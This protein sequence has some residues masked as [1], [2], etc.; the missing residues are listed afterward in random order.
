MKTLT[1]ACTE[2]MRRRPRSLRNRSLSHP[3]QGDPLFIVC[4]RLLLRCNPSTRIAETD[5][6]GRSGLRPFLLRWRGLF[7]VPIWI[8]DF[9]PF[10]TAGTVFAEHHDSRLSHV[11]HG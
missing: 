7:T 1:A 10:Y 6:A 8:R 4:R 5:W 11:D 3:S 9:V 2:R